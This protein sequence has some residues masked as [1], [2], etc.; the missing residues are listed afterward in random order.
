MAV[1]P[2]SAFFAVAR[3]V[4]LSTH[5]AVMQALAMALAAGGGGDSDGVSERDAAQLCTTLRSMAS[6][7]CDSLSLHVRPGASVL[8]VRATRTSLLR[9]VRT[10]G[11]GQLAPVRAF[12]NQP[13]ACRAYRVP[14]HVRWLPARR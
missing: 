2:P 6:T 4:A 14:W 3:A 12:Q 13:A 10:E 8:Y 1:C 7:I 11:A 9:A 5:R